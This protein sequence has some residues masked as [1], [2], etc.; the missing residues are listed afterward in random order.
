M[1]F[2]AIIFDVLGTYVFCESSVFDLPCNDLPLTPLEP[3][4]FRFKRYKL[5]ILAKS[6]QLHNVP[7]DCARELFQPSKDLVS[8]VFGDEKIFFRFCVRVFL[9]VMS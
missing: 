3:T 9:W 1:Q 8:L 6:L 2:C 5:P 4:K 7:V